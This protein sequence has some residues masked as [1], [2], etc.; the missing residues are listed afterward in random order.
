MRSAEQVIAAIALSLKSQ[1]VLG[2]V[3]EFPR[4]AKTLDD[5]K[6]LYVDKDRRLRGCHIE[7]V[8]GSERT[9]MQ[10]KSTA[11]DRYR[12]TLFLAQSDGDISYFAFLKMIEAVRDVLRFTTLD[13]PT[14]STCDPV[15]SEAY[16][17][18]ETNNY[19]MFG[20]VLCHRA[21]ISIPVVQTKGV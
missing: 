3:H 8:S 12:I 2:V 11:I 6:Q 17:Q 21:E 20:G 1:E 10:R 9:Q 13:S 15:S 14:L 5:L 16:C 18:L 19:V 7:L 4:Y